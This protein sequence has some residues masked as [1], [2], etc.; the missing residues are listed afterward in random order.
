MIFIIRDFFYFVSKYN[1]KLYLLSHLYEPKWEMLDLS[2]TI[3]PLTTFHIFVNFST[4]KKKSVNFTNY[5]KM[6]ATTENSNVYFVVAL[7]TI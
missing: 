4:P 3:I 1:C 2:L 7:L 6:L 5:I